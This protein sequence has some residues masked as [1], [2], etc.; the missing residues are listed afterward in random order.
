[1]AFRNTGT[2]KIVQKSITQQG[3]VEEDLFR[4][5]GGGWGFSYSGILKQQFVSDLQK[6]ADYVKM[7]NDL[8]SHKKEVVNVEKNTFSSKIILL[9]TMLQWQRNTGLNIK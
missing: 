7:Q 2:Q 3:I 6:A 4:S 9:Y 8:S 1:M 5:G